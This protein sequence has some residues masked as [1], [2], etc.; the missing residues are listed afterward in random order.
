MI[1]FPAKAEEEKRLQK[2]VAELLGKSRPD[3]VWVDNLPQNYRLWGIYPLFTKGGFLTRDAILPLGD[4]CLILAK[5]SRLSLTDASVE[6]SCVGGF[7]WNV[8][9]KVI[10][11]CPQGSV[12]A[13]KAD[14]DGEGIIRFP[15]SCTD[16]SVLG[17]GIRY[18]VSSYD[19]EVERTIFKS[20][21]STVFSFENALKLRADFFP[22]VVDKNRWE[23][24]E[25]ASV[26]SGFKSV[27]L[28][29]I[30]L[31]LPAGFR[32]QMVMGADVNGYESIYFTPSG[33]AKIIETMENIGSESGKAPKNS[34]NDTELMPGLS[35][36]EYIGVGGNVVFHPEGEAYF[37]EEEMAVSPT[38]SYLSFPGSTYY[39]QPQHSNFYRTE[40]VGIYEYALLPGVD[41]QDAAVPVFPFSRISRNMKEAVALENAYLCP[42][43]RK[44]VEQQIKGISCANEDVSY[45]VTRSGMM[46]AYT[47]K[48]MI[49]I[50]TVP[51]EEA[52]PGIGYAYMETK[53]WF[54]LLA[55][56]LFLPLVDLREWARTPYGITENRLK[57]AEK[58]GYTDAGK[59][60]KLCGQVYLS[61]EEIKEQ[62]EEKGAA[63]NEAIRTACT[64]FN[65]EIAGWEFR[66][67][68]QNWEKDQTLAILKL[69][70]CRTMEECMEEPSSWSIELDEEETA[71]AKKYFQKVKKLE[72]RLD[73][74][75]LQEILYDRTFR[76]SVF[77]RVGVPLSGL[78]KELAF[79]TKG[80]DPDKFYAIFVSYP[81]VSMASDKNSSGNAL[82]VYE[83]DEKINFEE[84]RE[85]GFLVKS[86]RLDIREGKIYDFRAKVQLLVNRL[87]GIDTVSMDGVDESCGVVFNG[88][89]QQDENGGYY[90]FE[91]DAPAEFV[92]RSNGILRVCIE[93]ASLRASGEE[94]SFL[95]G[96]S[97]KLT[98]ACEV[99]LL[100]Y[101][102]LSFAGLEIQMVSGSDG[103]R[104]E[105]VYRNLVLYPEKGVLRDASFAAL[106]PAK[107]SRMLS[108]NGQSPQDMGYMEIKL[109]GYENAEKLGKEWTGFVWRIETG[110]LGGLAA[111]ARLS[112]ELLTAFAPDSYSGDG[113]PCF[114]CGIKLDSLIN[115]DS[116]SLPLQGVVSLGFDAI[117]L[118]TDEDFYFRFRNFS[119]TILGKRFPDTN[120]DL[121]LIGDKDGN[122]GWYGAVE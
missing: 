32:F 92:M 15:F 83:N 78:P 113:G 20:L 62:V 94:S 98:G 34:V 69:T 68:P 99:D 101:D 44:A 100:S 108:G 104:F 102:A 118:K 97:M 50:Q 52:V 117:E 38:T 112:L 33:T 66:F 48:R 31:S 71:K 61:E 29:E 106:F 41:M 47:Q 37:G 87:F 115:T 8:E 73:T 43:R 105:A 72:N 86:I 110:N 75:M 25:D 91:M 80:I 109:K 24:E 1:L 14:I 2:C 16:L 36:T 46:A 96:G 56:E 3:L 84:F 28:N 111:A 82:L 13:S 74:E 57:N 5:D 67:A 27:R 114:Y 54:S 40:L 64:H 65:Q 81:S 45:A 30:Y 60:K 103:Y 9:G 4:Y 107:I 12:T 18:A 95:L 10:F 39:S 23:I 49:W 21:Y 17:A 122:L 19:S 120:N 58:N 121:Y 76:G 77:F 93:S 59:L 26:C 22:A 7:Q 6:G 85:Y 11:R 63:W 51:M 79:L 116:F 90:A 42:L 53:F 119:L 70:D 35:G 89:Y 88:S 55:A